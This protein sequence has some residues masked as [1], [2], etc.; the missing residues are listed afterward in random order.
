MLLDHS[1][2][3]GLPLLGAF[4]S[5]FQRVVTLKTG[6]SGTGSWLPD[7][8]LEEI[9]KPDPSFRFL[10]GLSELTEALAQAGRTTDA[11]ALIEAGIEHSAAGWLTPEL[12]RVWGEIFLL[13]SSPAAAERA[14]DLFRQ[15]LDWARRQGARSWELRAAT[16]LARLLRNQGRAADAQALLQPVYDQFTEG[17]ETA[18]LKMA[19]ALLDA[20]RGPAERS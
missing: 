18:D 14:E 12:L 16:S 1:S 6:N 15:A 4:G 20:L 3:H 8:G 10:A 17:F 9:A 11:L 5:R 19:E 13:R 7:S 2:K